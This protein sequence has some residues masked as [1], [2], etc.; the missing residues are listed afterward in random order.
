MI[1]WISV[2]LPRF[3]LDC[4]D[5]TVQ[6]GFHPHSLNLTPLAEFDSP[7]DV[8][9][10]RPGLH[11]RCL[12]FC[13]VARIFTRVPGFSLLECPDSSPLARISH[14]QPGFSIITECD[15][16]IL[17]TRQKFHC[18]VPGSHSIWPGLPHHACAW[19]SCCLPGLP[20]FSN[21]QA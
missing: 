4:P 15:A 8:V 9:T 20:R 7:S 10:G 6:P 18:P 21:C 14:K 16:R 5:F 17:P 1:D 19:S 3:S 2:H 12:G 13:S 11:S